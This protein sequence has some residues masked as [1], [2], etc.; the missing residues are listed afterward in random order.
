[1][2]GGSGGGGA[3]WRGSWLPKDNF[4]VFSSVSP[5]VL[6]TVL[7]SHTATQTRPQKL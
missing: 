3:W 5:P 4:H 6:S 1:M 2:L 7:L